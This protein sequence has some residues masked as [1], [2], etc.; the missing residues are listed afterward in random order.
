[1]QVIVLLWLV[2][3]QLT[4]KNYNKKRIVSTPENRIFSWSV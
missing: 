1:L 3:L 4:D 2:V